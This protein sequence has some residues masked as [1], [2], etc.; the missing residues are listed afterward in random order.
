MRASVELVWNGVF[1]ARYPSVW[2]LLLCISR[3]EAAI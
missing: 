2:S 3:L 1:Y